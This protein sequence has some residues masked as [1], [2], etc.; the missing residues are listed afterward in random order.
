MLSLFPLIFTLSNPTY[1]PLLDTLTLMWYS[2]MVVPSFDLTFLLLSWP[3]SYFMD[4]RYFVLC[5]YF[6]VFWLCM[7]F[8][9]F[10]FSSFFDDYLFNERQT[11]YGSLSHISYLFEFY[12]SCFL[13]KTFFLNMVKMLWKQYLFNG[14]RTIGCVLSNIVQLIE[15]YQKVYRTPYWPFQGTYKP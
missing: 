2:G 10:W 7:G 4:F 13:R 15:I 8:T 9:V 14:S 1:P 3:L 5:I 6:T 12:F 11:R